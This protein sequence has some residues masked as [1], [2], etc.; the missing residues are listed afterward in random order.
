MSGGVFLGWTSSKQRIKCLAQRHNAVPQVNL[1]PTIPRSWVQHSTTE[2]PCS[3]CSAYRPVNTAYIHKKHLYFQWCRWIWGFDPWYTNGLFLL[4]WYNKLGIVHCTY[5][6]VSAYN[7]QN[8]IVYFCLKIL[9]TLTNS[10][11]PDEMQRN[12]SNF[13]WVF[14]IYRL[15]E[16]L[17]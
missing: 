5:L 9:F 1:E 10:V 11:D 6:G 3:K 13:I 12:A 4:F 15:P 17:I 7:F 14:T 2:Q 16:V 8:N